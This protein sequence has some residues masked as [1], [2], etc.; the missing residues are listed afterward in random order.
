ML[1]TA[2]V[3]CGLQFT[4]EGPEGYV[5]FSNLT[6]DSTLITIPPGKAG[7]YV[8][9]VRG[10]TDQTGA[11]SFMIRDGSITPL[12]LGVPF[13]DTLPG[14]RSPRWFK[15][16][17]PSVGQLL[18]TLNDSTNADRNQLYLQRRRPGADQINH[19]I[20]RVDLASIDGR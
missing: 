15:V 13:S 2:V 10:Q 6:D 14:S 9:T 1:P 19:A 12:V 8:L 4:L 5:V 7:N 17:L 3:T 20:E 11:Y 18:V 16:T